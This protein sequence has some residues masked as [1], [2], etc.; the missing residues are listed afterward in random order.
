MIMNSKKN[1]VEGNQTYE[2]QL[3]H[4]KI[5]PLEDYLNDNTKLLS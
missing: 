4:E 3:S 1:Y 5:D 2:G